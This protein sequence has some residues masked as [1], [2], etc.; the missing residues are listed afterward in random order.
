MDKNVLEGYKTKS[1]DKMKAGQT[2]EARC[3]AFLD[4]LSENLHAMIKKAQSGNAFKNAELADAQATLD[5]FD[6]NRQAQLDAI[7]KGVK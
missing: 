7:F 5:H 1:L 3:K 4:D 2:P 6:A